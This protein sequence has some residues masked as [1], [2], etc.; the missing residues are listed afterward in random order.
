[1]YDRTK[2][3]ITSII[4]CLLPAVH[5]FPLNYNNALREK[6]AYRLFITFMAPNIQSANIS[7]TKIS[8]NENVYIAKL[9][10]YHLIILTKPFPNVYEVNK[11][12]YF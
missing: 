3:K 1:M 8:R 6:K 9:P 5:L 12:Q 11:K 7:I 4:W 2:K 10:A